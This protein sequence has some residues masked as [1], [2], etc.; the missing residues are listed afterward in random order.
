M[1]S[2]TTRH[3]GEVRI[4]AESVADHE[5][6]RRIVTAAF[7]RAAEAEL[8]DAVRR[9][10][11]YV[12][13]MA[14]VAEHG[15]TIVGHVMVSHTTLR[16]LRGEHRVAL[17]APLAV[18][19]DHQGRGVGAALVRAVAAVADERGEP[20]LLLEG[21]PAYY[22]RLGFEAASNHGIALP[23]PTGVPADVAQVLPLSADDRELRGAVVYPSAFDDVT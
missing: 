10:P 19:P 14:L 9:S 11:G 4:R 5:A 20:I 12:P 3:T 21:D 16:A 23:L 17:L 15:G 18:A 2:D 13:A 6:I 22:G 8:I 7:G 1:V